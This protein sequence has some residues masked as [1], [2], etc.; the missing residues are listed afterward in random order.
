M[1]VRP[2]ENYVRI[3]ESEYNRRLST[4]FERGKASVSSA[5]TAALPATP[6]S[7]EARIAANYDEMIGKAEA[8][9][10]PGTVAKL[11]AEKAAKMQGSS[12]PVSYSRSEV[13]AEAKR[14]GSHHQESHKIAFKIR[15]YID[16]ERAAG[17]RMHHAQAAHELRQRGEI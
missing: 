7:A 4:E 2:N 8:A 12:L 13:T 17:R 1:S 3:T 11:R 6:P 5:A 16:K 15:D 14:M 10:L 9:G